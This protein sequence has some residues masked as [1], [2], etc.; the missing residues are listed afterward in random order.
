MATSMSVVKASPTAAM[1]QATQATIARALIGAAF[2]SA[3]LHGGVG[4]SVHAGAPA[5]LIGEHAM[6]GG[7]VLTCEPPITLRREIC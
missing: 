1:A 2:P 7:Q 3:L 4:L 5:Y 6:F